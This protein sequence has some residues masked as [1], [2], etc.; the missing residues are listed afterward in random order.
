M[1]EQQQQQAQFAAGSLQ[2]VQQPMTMGMDPTGAGGF[3]LP[4]ALL[5]QYPALS[6][7]DWSALPQ[8][9]DTGDLSDVG[10]G[11]NSFD[12]GNGGDFG[13]DESGLNDGYVNHNG[14]NYG[15]G[16]AEAAGGGGGEGSVGHQQAW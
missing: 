12:A 16:G 5:A 14:M 2:P 1:I 10:M 6:N 15:G 3:A 7:I 9:D 11:S 13:Y 4:A 8:G